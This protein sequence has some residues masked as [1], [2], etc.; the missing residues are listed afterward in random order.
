MESCPSSLRLET[1]DRGVNVCIQCHSPV[2]TP[3]EA[4]AF[5]ERVNEKLGTTTE[6]LSQVSRC[7]R[8]ML[9]TRTIG[10]RDDHI[11]I[12]TLL[13]PSQLMN[14]TSP[15]LGGA[16]EA[17][18][19][20]DEHWHRTAIGFDA[21]DGRNGC[22]RILS[23]HPQ[24]EVGESMTHRPMHSEIGCT[25]TKLRRRSTARCGWKKSDNRRRGDNRG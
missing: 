7:A 15:S 11:L 17:Q 16:A 25:L 6:D 20:V 14:Q 2:A 5:C 9:P 8:V 13:H 3:I 10:P 21:G 19:V 12:C 18:V 24:N 23:E 22:N 4:A 1:C